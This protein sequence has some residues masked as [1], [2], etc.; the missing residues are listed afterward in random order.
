MKSLRV[1]CIALCTVL[2]ISNTNAQFLQ[3]RWHTP[4]FSSYPASNVDSFAIP[5]RQGIHILFWNRALANGPSGSW[6]YSWMATPNGGVGIYTGRI[7]NNGD[8]LWKVTV[9]DGPGKQEDP[10][11]LGTPD[12]GVVIAWVDYRVGSYNGDTNYVGNG[13]GSIMAQKL[14]S[15]GHRLWNVTGETDTINAFPVCFAIGYQ[16]DIRIISDGANGVYILWEDGRNNLGQDIY[17]T[18]ILANGTLAP[19]FRMNGTPVVYASGNQPVNGEYT[20]DTDG[21]NGAWIA[22]TDNRRQ[23]SDIYI[24][25]L[26]NNGTT[27][28]DSTGHPFDT[29]ISEQNKVKLTPDGRG[30]AFLVWR[31]ASSL[32]V[33]LYMQHIDSAGSPMWQSDT[34]VALGTWDN[35]QTNPRIIAAG[36]DTCI[37]TWED[38]RNDPSGTN[39]EDVYAQKVTG[40]TTLVRVWNTNG[41]AVCTQ[42][43]HQRETRIANDGLNGAVIVWQDERSNSFGSSAAPNEDA[44][45]QYLNSEGVPQWT[46]DGLAIAAQPGAQTQIYAHENNNRFIFVWTDTRKGSQPFYATILNRNGTSVTG[47]PAD[48]RELVGDIGGN[49]TKNSIVPLGKTRFANFWVDGRRY[50]YGNRIYYQVSQFATGTNDSV[51]KITAKNGT[52]ITLD[53]TNTIDQNGTLIYSDPVTVTTPD[54]GAIVVYLNIL[55]L[56]IVNQIHTIRAQKISY[57]GNRMWGPY[58]VEVC[59][60]VTQ[61]DFFSGAPDGNGGAYFAYTV[62]GSSPNYYNEVHVQHIDANGN[63][64][65]G[66]TGASV[67]PGHEQVWS[68][69][70]VSGSNVY[71]GLIEVYDIDYYLSRVRLL[72]LNSDGSANWTRT[73]IT[74]FDSL[75]VSSIGSRSKLRLIPG[76]NGSVVAHWEEFRFD[77][78]NG[79]G[80]QIYAQKID[81]TGAFLWSTNG[82]RLGATTQ[83]ESD[84]CAVNS[85]NTY[86]F[87]WKDYR[88]TNSTASQIY[89]QHLNDNGNFLLDS[90]GLALHSAPNQQTA[91]YLV[92]DGNAGVYTFYTQFYDGVNNYP[93]PDT[94]NDADLIGTH[95]LSDGTVYRPEL[96][97]PQG[98]GSSAYIEKMLDVQTH[99]VGIPVFSGDGINGVIVN[100]LDDRATH[101]EEL[102]NLYMQRVRDDY[103]VSVREI[104][105]PIPKLFTLYQN[106]PNP[107]N[108]TTTF[109]FTIPRT[110]HV[111][112]T[113]Y[114][115]LGREVIRLL[116]DVKM[117]GTYELKWSGKNTAGQEIA[118]G[119]YFYRMETTQGA[120]TRKM[121]LLK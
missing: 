15:L 4:Q 56:S 1:V 9:N 10:V 74:G 67:T 88:G 13:G 63:Q 86:W 38:F 90:T 40:D 39:N 27:R 37:V 42:T 79:S 118:S 112:F 84:A 7:S 30:G 34:G 22:W 93:P 47:F 108:P 46:T 119:M 16:N 98:A 92:P 61:P 70:A 21:R 91:Q 25:Q 51:W 28:W 77:V 60:Q 53:S 55:Q 32:T 83:T 33:D 110:G 75:G 104:S 117:T 68:A 66:T 41:V 19:G 96:W 58:G 31:N 44:Y 115:V 17:G 114:D 23:N 20:V 54:S 64:L 76:S 85:A 71:L 109:R 62:A 107:F 89:L 3:N 69:M 94:I 99:P 57:D 45:A 87:A 35:E 14:D 113:I 50:Q 121:T 116:D 52:P 106:Y 48:G 82:V 6:Y 78:A 24:Q 12:G 11:C 97:T 43:D 80:Q 59:S 103:V 73:I 65:Y 111:K 36:I 5:V 72:K 101:K 95:I 49:V 29:T 120:I 8:T 18:R 102:T 26:R 100:W 105:S 81:S 2:W